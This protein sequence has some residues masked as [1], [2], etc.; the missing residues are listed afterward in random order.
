MSVSSAHGRPVGMVHVCD[1][2][3][4]MDPWVGKSACMPQELYT[5]DLSLSR[6]RGYVAG[7]RPF[8]HGCPRLE[9]EAVEGRVI[10]HNYGHGGSGIT[11][12]WGSANEMVDQLQPWLRPGARVAVLGSGIMGLCVSSLLLDAGQKVTVYARDFPPNTT[13]NVAG[14]LWSPT[15]VGLGS[16]GAD[17]ERQERLL[18]RSWQSFK[19]LDGERFGIEEVPLFTTDDPAHPLDPMPEGLVDP[20][21]RLSRLPFTGLAPPGKAAR[22]LLV[23]TPRFLDTLFQEVRGR[24]ARVEQRAF[25]SLGE[26]L[27]LEEKVLVN[28]LGL[29][30]R[31]VAPDP[32]VSPI[33]GQLVLLDPAPRPFMLDHAYGYVIS[34]RDVLILGGTFEEGIDDPDAVE[35]VCA[36]ILRGHRRFFGMAPQAP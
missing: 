15:H 29:G 9:V 25:S 20:P 18:R 16:G 32:L 23:E 17:A 30:A 34:R 24:G 21:L 36:E 35:E 26:T 28:C 14:G 10:G 8:R 19:A 7:L 2:D 31:E 22:T 13:S 1:F 11:M 3:P 12:C 33:K 27:A 6:V 4:G 5:V